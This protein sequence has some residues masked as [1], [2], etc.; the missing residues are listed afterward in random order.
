MKKVLLYISNKSLLIVLKEKIMNKKK[1]KLFSQI[2][3]CKAEIDNLKPNIDKCDTIMTLYNK[4]IIEKAVL[5]KELNEV[6][7]NLMVR[8]VRKFTP[9]KERTIN[10][11]FVNP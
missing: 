1:A 9:K 11:Y 6:E 10:D 8:L 2:I 5:T 3:K 4:K 7:D